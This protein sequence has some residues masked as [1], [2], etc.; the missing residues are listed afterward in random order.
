MTTSTAQYPIT[1]GAIFSRRVLDAATTRLVIRLL[2]D[3][4]ITAFGLAVAVVLRSQ[5]PLVHHWLQ[6]TS[7]GLIATLLG[8][9]VIFLW[10]AYRYGLYRAEALSNPLS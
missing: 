7:K 10:I 8:Y 2:I 6:G 9:L 1:S 5:L 4:I 3:A